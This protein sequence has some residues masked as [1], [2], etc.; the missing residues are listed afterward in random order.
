MIEVIKEYGTQVIVTTDEDG[1]RHKWRLKAIGRG[2]IEMML[3]SLHST[4]LY[5]TLK[6]ASANVIEV[7]PSDPFEGLKDDDE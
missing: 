4:S 5:L 3:S 6:P 7:I 2:G 1:H